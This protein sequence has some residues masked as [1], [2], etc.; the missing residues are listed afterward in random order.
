MAGCFMSSREAEKIS[1]VKLRAEELLRQKLTPL[2]KVEVD[3]MTPE[4]RRVR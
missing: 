3:A 4:L 2:R 1:D